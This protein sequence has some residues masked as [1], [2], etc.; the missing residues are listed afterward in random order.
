MDVI[1][2]RIDGLLT[3]LISSNGK[4]SELRKDYCERIRGD[5]NNPRQTD[6]RFSDKGKVTLADL[7]NGTMLP[8]KDVEA[9]A[10]FEELPVVFETPIY[11]FDIQF[12]EN[13]KDLNEESIEVR[14]HLNDV[15]K[16]F[17]RRGRILFAEMSFVN[18][19]GK[20]RLEI[21]FKRG[22][23]MNTKIVTVNK[24]KFETVEG[25]PAK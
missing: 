1:R 9:G 22:M 25:C 14:H 5:D 18:E 7:S 24:G 13:L 11:F 8:E 16:R 20:F 21:K 3:V 10:G 4:L 12:D 23:N 17:Y 15:A 2:Y 19:P 6:Y